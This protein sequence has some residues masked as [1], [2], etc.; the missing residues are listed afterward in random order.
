MAR[1]DLST[2]PL[3]TLLADPDVKAIL[4]KHAPG[5]TSNPMIG[6]VSGMPAQQAVGMA[7]GFIGQDAVTAIMDEVGALE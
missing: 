1:Y 3:G 2:T 7:G 6:M 4:E 5:V